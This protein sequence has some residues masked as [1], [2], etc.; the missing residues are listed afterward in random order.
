MADTEQAT[1][2]QCGVRL[3]A[4]DPPRLCLRCWLTESSTDPHAIP[5]GKPSSLVRV[6]RWPIRASS[7]LLIVALVCGGLWFWYY[8]VQ[9]EIL[10]RRADVLV[11][12]RRLDEAIVAYRAALRIH[13][14]IALAH[15]KLGN[16]LIH[17]AKR[18]E[19]YQVKL[20]E[21]IGEYRKAIGCN[22]ALR[23]A[24]PILGRALKDQGKFVE[25]IAAY[26]NAIR[27][28]IG[29]EMVYYDLG[30]AERAQKDADAAM[31]AYRDAVWLQPTGV[32]VHNNL[33]GV[34]LYKQERL[35][36]AIAAFREAIR[37]EPSFAEAYINLGLA[38]DRQ[39]KPAEAI[40]ALRAAIRLDPTGASAYYNLGN[41]LAHHSKYVEALDEYRAAI[42]HQPDFA[43]SPVNSRNAVDTIAAYR[44]LIKVIPDDAAANRGLAWALLFFSKRQLGDFYEA[45]R[46]AREAVALAPQDEKS[47]RTLALAEY[48]ERNWN[49][50]L[51]A[52]EKLTAL[53]N[54]RTA[55][56]WFI[57]SLVHWRRGDKERA[58]VSF[59]EAVTRTKP[60][61][62]EDT[63]LCQLWTE[64]AELL[65][66]AGPR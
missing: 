45:L 6:R 58:R 36:E 40:V 31:A 53:R 46:Y 47:L 7:A 25:S 11:T 23:E 14:G 33:L 29:G 16:A 51:A 28:G 3:S 21:A 27:F 55:I 9:P 63:E 38:L 60:D 32:E 54:G 1:C 66:L 34:A 12:E 2:Q 22:P 26:Q 49:N 61:V 52:I 39:G 20:D 50:A 37:L 18:D 10:I 30:D 64:A 42:R 57:L 19:N 48:R 35:N 44:E 13:P 5:P 24:Y 17:L 43:T 59:N 4:D 62:A 8:W 65:G 56:D 41:T 15:M